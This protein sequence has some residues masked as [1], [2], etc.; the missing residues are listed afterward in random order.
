MGNRPMAFRFFLGALGG[1]DTELTQPIT[2]TNGNLTKVSGPLGVATVGVAGRSYGKRSVIGLDWRGSYRAYSKSR[3]QLNSFDNFLSVNYGYQ[4][5]ART[6]VGLNASLSSYSRAYGG[7][8]NPVTT[9]ITDDIANPADEGFDGRTRVVAGSAG[10]HHLL[11]RRWQLTMSGTAFLVERHSDALI[12][13]RGFRTSGGIAYLLGPKSSIG[14]KYDFGDYHYPGGHGDTWLHQAMLTYSKALSPIWNFTAGAG[15]YRAENERTVAVP[16]DPVIAAIV[17][18]ATTMQPMHNIRYGPAIA[19]TLAGQF[20]RSTAS[21]YYHRG[22][23][24]G[25]GFITT[26]AADTFGARYS[27]LATSR[28]N[29]GLYGS[30]SLRIG[31]AQ[32]DTKYYHAGTGVGL[33]YRFAGSFHFTAAVNFNHYEVKDG[34]LDRNR[35]SAR[36]GITWSPG[37]IPLSLF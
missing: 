30:Y 26:A 16:L 17:G 5:S 22:V 34:N 18:E 11:T 27:Y 1:Y 35:L 29:V 7:L 21:F 31:I 28:L 15:A 14:V 32:N 13:S 23:R 19:A 24:P 8:Y 9:D 37:D 3:N 20:Q 12:N 25:N 4:A 10:I 33:N 36:A 6:Q 2:D